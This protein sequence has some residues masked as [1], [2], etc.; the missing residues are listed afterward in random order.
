ME[1]LEK[2]I[3][4]FDAIYIISAPEFIYELKDSP[5]YK[6][7]NPRLHSFNGIQI[8]FDYYVPLHTV[9]L[10]TNTEEVTINY[11]S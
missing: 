5:L 8:L 9:R 10:V 2:Y 4:E 7:T 11:I 3:N 6:T 1:E